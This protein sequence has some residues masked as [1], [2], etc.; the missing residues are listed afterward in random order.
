MK[1]A[2]GMIDNTFSPVRREKPA[3]MQQDSDGRK[4]AVVVL[5]FTLECLERVSR[6][7]SGAGV[8][9]GSKH[10]R[11]S[12]QEEERQRSTHTHTG[13]R[14]ERA[15]HTQKAKKRQEGGRARRWVR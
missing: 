8:Q 14:K 3:P 4:R 9:C 5:V 2:H 1:N 13:R 7:A 12:R 11:Y 6:I 15:A 10:T